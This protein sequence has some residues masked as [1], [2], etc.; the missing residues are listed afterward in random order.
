MML[1]SVGDRGTAQ[2]LVDE[3]FAQA[4][5]SWRTVSRHLRMACSPGRERRV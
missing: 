2:D 1:V 4:F 5:A 3:A